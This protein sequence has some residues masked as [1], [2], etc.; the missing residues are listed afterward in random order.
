MWNEDRI[1]QKTIIIIKL[2]WKHVDAAERNSGDAASTLC[3]RMM[4]EYRS[5]R[6]A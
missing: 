5:N 2:R 3:E 4:L 1:K 6:L